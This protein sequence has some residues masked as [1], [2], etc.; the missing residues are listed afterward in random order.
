MRLTIDFETRSAED[1]KKAG[2]W[3]Y[4][5]HWSTD[6]VCLGVGVN[7]S[8]PMIWLPPWVLTEGISSAQLLVM[9][10]KDLEHLISNAEAI[11]AHNM[12]FERAVWRHVMHVKYGFSDLRLERCHCSAAK[13]AVQALPRKLESVG[14]VLGLTQQKD[15]DG[16]RTMLRV[17]RPRTARKEEKA[18]FPN[19]ADMTFW[20]TGREHLLRTIHY[21]LQ[22]VRTERELSSKLMDLTPAA[23]QVWLLDQK[24]NERGFFCDKEA[25]EAFIQLTQKEKARLRAEFDRDISFGAFT[26]TQRAKFLEWL[27]ANGVN[28]P[29]MKKETVAAFL[30]S[31][32]DEEDGDFSEDVDGVPYPLS[33]KVK[34]ALEIRKETNRTSTA[35]FAALL[36]R[37]SNDGRVRATPMFHGAGT[38]RWSGK[39]F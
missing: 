14:K 9:S 26:P 17:S 27:K 24:I 37:R 30:G 32:D 16:H 15:S 19:W 4:A 20:E 11:E 12:E 28:L 21:C 23:R 39:G 13:A 35:K 31:E 6:V 34:R 38:G 3:H 10:N 5:E 18:Q 29:D 1:L 25:I 7:D 36:S 8:Q 33:P 22:D 2:P